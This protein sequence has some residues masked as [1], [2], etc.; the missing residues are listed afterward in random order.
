MKTNNNLTTRIELVTPSKAQQYLLKNI[1][2]RPLTTQANFYAELMKRGKWN[3]TGQGISFD[4]NGN[5]ID[6]QHRLKAVTIANIPVEFLIIEGVMPTT[7]EDYDT[8]YKRTA[9]NVFDMKGIK[10]SSVLAAACRKIILYNN[11]RQSEHISSVGHDVTAQKIFIDA[12]DTSNRALLEFYNKNKT[13]L[14]IAVVKTN[15][16]DN[17]KLLLKSQT[18]FL[19]Y[20]LR[21]HEDSFRF[22]EMLIK[23]IN[24][25]PK[26][27]HYY[28]R[29]KFLN[30]R[31][32]YSEKNVMVITSYNNWHQKS[33]VAKPKYNF[34][35]IPVVVKF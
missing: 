6:G 12:A 28:L 34:D 21:N 9:G 13:E 15:K 16:L 11:K 26:S 32:T 25:E 17:N 2:N 1:Q 7:Q 14:D 24:I 33:K 4:T 10:N 35:V 19:F 22:M 8:G 5:L 20:L 30:E 23:G 31:Y 18:V 27:I 29:N 3:L